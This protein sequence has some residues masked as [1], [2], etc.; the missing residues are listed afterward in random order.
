MGR[1]LTNRSLPP[2]VLSGG[3]LIAASGLLALALPF[4]GSIAGAW[5]LEA[6]GALLV[7]GIL[8]TGLAYVLNYRIITEDGP[9]LA[10]TV[11]YLLPIVAVIAGVTV[12]DEQI[13]AW[14]V[15]GVVVVLLGV[16]LARRTQT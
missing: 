6:V 7:L 5:R 9:L 14:L 15:A 4:G 12:L 3:Q 2:L 8:S 16:G 1:Y 11:T 10:S 13:A